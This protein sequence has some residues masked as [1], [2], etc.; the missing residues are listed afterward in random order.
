MTLRPDQQLIAHWIRP[1][2]RVLDLGCG[3]G[4]LLAA[5]REE[6]GVTGYG[7]EIE[8][9][10]VTQCLSAGINV[11]HGN[12]DQGLS[13]FDQDSFDHV[14]MTQTLQAVRFPLRLLNEMLR[15]GRE[16][17]VTFPNMGHWRA[18][19]Q[20]LFGRMPVT[21]ALPSTWYD[22]ENIHLCTIRDFEDLCRA[23][24]LQILDRTTVD[25][26]H[27]AG[28]LMR[29]APNLLGEV[30]LFRVQRRHRGG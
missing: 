2:S 25:T 29:L 27:Q 8:P 17:I 23:E 6:H 30:A 24:G 7:I 9:E 10:N 22:T 26:E 15:V 20:I 13:D 21:N 18:R 16:G 14:I 4:A 5:L 28:F 1:R 3:D 12:L 19:K 11:I